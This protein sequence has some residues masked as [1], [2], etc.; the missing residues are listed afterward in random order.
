MIPIEPTGSLST[1]AVLIFVAHMISSCSADGTLR[2]FTAPIGA[3]VQQYGEGL[4]RAVL[5]GLAGGSP[6]P[7][8]PFLSDVLHAVASRFGELAK[9]WVYAVLASGG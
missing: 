6:S 5:L 3:C 8:F 9:P 7:M 2:E 1:R 4:V